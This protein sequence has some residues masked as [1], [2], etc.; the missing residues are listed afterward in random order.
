TLNGGVG[1]NETIFLVAEQNALL[2]PI[3]LH[4]QS[5]AGDL[6]EYFD[7]HNPDSQA[8]TVTSTMVRRSGQADVT[9]DGQ[10]ALFV[11][12]GRTPGPREG[13]WLESCGWRSALPQRRERRTYAR[14]GGDARQV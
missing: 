10:F 6:V 13:D 5:A 9:F 3:N 7:S 14:P 2:G 8:Y 11:L 1:P 4:I 12:G